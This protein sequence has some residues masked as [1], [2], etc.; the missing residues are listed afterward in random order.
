MKTRPRKCTSRRI[1]GLYESLVSYLWES[2]LGEN[3]VYVSARI[4]KLLDACEEEMIDLKRR[5]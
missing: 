1:D 3:T 2:A 5:Q 4:F